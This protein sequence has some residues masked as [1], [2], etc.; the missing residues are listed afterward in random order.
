MKAVRGRIPS[1]L[2]VEVLMLTDA[3]TSRLDGLAEAEIDERLAA[4]LEGTRLFRV[5][6][7]VMGPNSQ[8]KTTD[9]DAKP[10]R[11]NGSRRYRPPLAR[12]P[13][14]RCFS[15]RNPQ[16]PLPPFPAAGGHSAFGLWHSALA[17]RVRAPLRVAAK[18]ALAVCRSFRTPQSAFERAVAVFDPIVRTL[19][20]SSALPRFC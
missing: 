11:S 2:F 9:S 14:I 6:R 13:V 7:Q 5:F 20:K 8:P 3:A 16:L 1:G 4:F 19:T 18:R 17:L 10:L 15:I 12:R